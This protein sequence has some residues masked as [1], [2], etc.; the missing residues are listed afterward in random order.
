MELELTDDNFDA[1][2]LKSSV[3][4]L[5]D[6]WAP[7]CGPCRMMAPTIESLAKELD[8]K[9]KVGKVNIDEHNVYAGKFNIM[10]IP[11]FLIFKDGSVVEQLVGVIDKDEMK[12]RIEKH[13]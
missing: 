6:F 12:A 8:G 13:I 9:V 1:E 10:S 5:V 2:V 4:V 7:W 3:P 11:T